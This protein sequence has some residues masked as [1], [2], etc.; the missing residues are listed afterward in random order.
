MPRFSA[1]LGFLFNEV[2]FIDRFG[3]AAHAG[4]RA[5][6]FPSPYDTQLREIVAQIEHHKLDVVLINAPAG[7]WAAGERGI[8]SLDG[9]EHDFAAA[10]VMALRYANALR[11]PRVHVMAGTLPADAD[12]AERARRR[13]TYIR[14]LRYACEEALA[15][16]VTVLIEPINTRD[17]PGYFLNTQADA[18]AIRDEVGLPNLKV[19]MDLYHA[20]VVEGDLAT[21]IRRYL[22]QVGHI[23]IA[24]TPGRHEPDNG[25]INYSFLFRLLD[26][27]KYTGYIGCEYHPERGTAEGLGWMY[28]LIDRL[29][30]KAGG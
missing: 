19:Q 5:V 20:Q 13:R 3:E 4:F 22:P 1:N 17:V 2:P 11:C 23:Q 27:L 16:N 9:R 25:E 30:L 14:N 12:A 6:E 28:K 7:D 15:Q 21:K 8:A 10:M 24:G 26:E 29:P 18:H